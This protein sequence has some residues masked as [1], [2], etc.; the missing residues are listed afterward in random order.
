[1]PELR[2]RKNSSE[3]LGRFTLS[4]VL[5]VL[6]LIVVVAFGFSLR[7]Q[8]FAQSEVPRFPHGD[9]AKY[10]LYAY[11]VS[12]F[13]I[14]GFG[15]LQVLPPDTSADVVTQTLKPDALVTPGY[16]LF[17]SLFLGGEYT[18]QQRD[19]IL[20]MQVI[21]S[22]ATILIAYFAFAAVGRVYALS[23][24]ALIACSP[25]LV[26]MNLYFL[27]ET[28]FCFF[29]ILFVWLLN[30]ANAGQK[31]YF[32][33]LL[34]AALALAALTRPWI[35]GYLIVVLAYL[36]FSTWNIG[37]RNAVLVCIGVAILL[38]P[39]MIRNKTSLGT[40]ADPALAS[41]SIH[42][43]MYP[44]MMYERQP[45]TRGYAYRADPMSDIFKGSAT[46]TLVEL[47]KRASAEPVKYLEWFTV[48]KIRTV[49]SWGII[50]GADPIFVYPIGNSPYFDDPKFYLSSYYMEKIHGALVVLALIGTLTVWL[51]SR[52]QWADG[53]P[54]LFLRA[55]S[56]LVLYF[57]FMHM[58][59]APYPRYSIPMRP[60]IYA[61]SLYS[62]LLAARA[63]HQ[64]FAK[65]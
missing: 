52:F 44:D 31:P 16:P 9:A 30:S 6:S 49:L 42:H 20:L 41:T 13:E 40:F 54:L 65:A 15:D 35:Q 63:V 59:G 58:I 22:T 50:A 1:M 62:L 60:V 33:L 12:N 18:T 48:G 24:A 3:T 7:L 26:N 55:I 39:W 51:P 28:L 10:F 34:G 53:S 43:G 5:A 37:W 27:T 38:A 17:M 57:L 61:M 19:S 64:R 8:A 36:V 21:L 47:K 56:L 46:A 25:H 11:N 45:D 32:F 14:Y 4:E 29:L 23:L 2:N